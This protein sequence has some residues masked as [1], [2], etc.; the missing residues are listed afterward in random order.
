ME[1]IAPAK[2]NLY[3]DVLSKREDGYHEI[4]TLFEKVSLFDRLIVEPA[5]RATTIIC[6]DPAVPTGEESLMRRVIDAFNGQ[7][8]KDLCFKVVL[9]KNIPVSAGLGGGSS[10]AAA[11]LK[12]LN[13]TTG[14]PLDK[15]ALINIAQALGADIP[16]F[17]S[18]ASFAYGR[19]RGD[20]IQEVRS[21]LKMWHV[22]INPPFKVSTKE[23]YTRLTH[24][25]LTNNRGV[26]R[27]FSAFLSAEDIDG[28]AKNLHN[29][30]QQITLRDFPVLEQVLFELKKAGAKAVLL[31]GSGPCVFGIFE[32]KEAETAREAL[33]KVF[34]AEESWKIFVASTY[35]A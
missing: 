8:G 6:D 27:M 22:I 20:I 17:L 18:D 9:E 21:G 26:D 24:F 12:A 33:L 16:F 15:G 10:D 30:L 34:P 4:E 31:T 32:P 28:I 25:G 14:S 19:G 13:E 35:F 7:I 3:L 29:D 11:L 2:I 5:E 1:F 23:V